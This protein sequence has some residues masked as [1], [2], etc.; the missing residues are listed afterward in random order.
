VS[1]IDLV[2][3]PASNVARWNGWRLLRLAARGLLSAL[4]ESR[5]RAARNI[6]RDNSHLLP[7]QVGANSF[8]EGRKE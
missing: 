5:E 4:Q 1:K 3:A 6:I 2:Y 7:D 8:Q